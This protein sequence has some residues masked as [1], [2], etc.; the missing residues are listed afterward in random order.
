[1]FNPLLRRVA[2]LLAKGTFRDF[3]TVDEFLDIVLPEEGIV[4]V[5]WHPNFL[6]RLVYE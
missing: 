2:I 4:R 6:E 1:M 5:H 3:K